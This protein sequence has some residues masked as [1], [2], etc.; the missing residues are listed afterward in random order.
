MPKAF[1]NCRWMNRNKSSNYRLNIVETLRWF[2]FNF[3]AIIEIIFDSIHVVACYAPPCPLC[4]LIFL[5]IIQF[6]IAKSCT[7][8]IRWTSL[9]EKATFSFFG[10]VQNKLFLLTI[11]RFSGIA[12]SLFRSKGSTS[13]NTHKTEIFYNKQIIYYIE[14]YIIKYVA[15][16]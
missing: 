6:V 7:K 5:V 9:V 8:C 10:F 16:D 15:L 2:C 11:S 1:L 12:I 3:I 4:L 13:R 14:D